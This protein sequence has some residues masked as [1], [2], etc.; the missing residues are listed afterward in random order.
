VSLSVG[1]GDPRVGVR[2]K[3]G[4][5]LVLSPGV[6]RWSGTWDAEILCD[7]GGRCRVLRP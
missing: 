6:I 5:T 2:G 3:L 1:A 4:G 7:P